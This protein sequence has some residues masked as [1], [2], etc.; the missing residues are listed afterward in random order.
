MEKSGKRRTKALTDIPDLVAFL[1]NLVDAGD[2][3]AVL[4]HVFGEIFDGGGDFF[5]LLR[6]GGVALAD[7][8]FSGG[9]ALGDHFWLAGWC[10][11]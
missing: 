1:D 6:D 2:H 10:R 9:E 3:E 11:G 5:D 8:V 7:D 4:E